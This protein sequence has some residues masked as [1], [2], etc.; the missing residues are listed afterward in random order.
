MHT[1]IPIASD[2]LQSVREHLSFH[3]R[4]KYDTCLRTFSRAAWNLVPRQAT[5][6]TWP[7]LAFFFLLELV[8]SPVQPLLSPNVIF[9]PAIKRRH[10]LS[11]VVLMSIDNCE[12]SGGRGLYFGF[13][14]QYLLRFL[15]LNLKHIFLLSFGSCTVWTLLCITSCGLSECRKIKGKTHRV[16]G[17]LLSL[18]KFEIYYIV[19]NCQLLNIIN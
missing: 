9:N 4:Y 13:N 16:T 18:S 19:C 10:A 3:E 14:L 8:H 7:L 12:W 1:V 11:S 6:L 2:V 17:F 5:D 15:S